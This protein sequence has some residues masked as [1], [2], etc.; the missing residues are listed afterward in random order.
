MAYILYI[1]AQHEK[2]FTIL[3]FTIYNARTLLELVMK[4]YMKIKTLN[5]ILYINELKKMKI[6]EF[7]Y[8]GSLEQ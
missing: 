1:S 3:Y 2:L 8:Y 6:F 4:P 5:A 7:C